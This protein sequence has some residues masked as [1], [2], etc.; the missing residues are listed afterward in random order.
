M[1]ERVELST[2]S[3]CTVVIS[4]DVFVVMWCL[5]LLLVCLCLVLCG[6]SC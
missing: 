4:A 3:G 2:M 6:P 5:A 1:I